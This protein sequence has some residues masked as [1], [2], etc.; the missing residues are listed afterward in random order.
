MFFVVVVVV[1]C[2]CFFFKFCR[3]RTTCTV[4]YGVID[5]F[6]LSASIS[7]FFS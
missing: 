7:S 3:L 6:I 2:V 4:T 5:N 1:V